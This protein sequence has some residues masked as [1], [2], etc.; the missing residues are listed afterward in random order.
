MKKIPMPSKKD[1]RRY[2]ASFTNC[3][4]GKLAIFL[5]LFHRAV[6]VVYEIPLPGMPMVERTPRR[7][8]LVVKPRLPTDKLVPLVLT[9]TRTPGAILMLF[10]NLS[11]I[12]A[13]IYKCFRKV[14]HHHRH[15]SVYCRKPMLV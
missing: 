10:L 6:R 1:T 15:Q 12:L 2:D 5:R 7:L 3:R 14:C 9:L 4:L 13:S 11:P 8:I